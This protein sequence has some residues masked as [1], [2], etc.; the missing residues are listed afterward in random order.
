MAS[1]HN[2]SRRTMLRLG[3]GGAAAVAL[4]PMG[5]VSAFAAPRR[6]AATGG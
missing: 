3:V 4:A 1:N 6:A 5:P 2:L